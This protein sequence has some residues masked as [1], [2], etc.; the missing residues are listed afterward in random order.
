MFA[1]Y[2]MVPVEKIRGATILPAFCISL[3]AK[4]SVV[5][6][7]GR[8]SGTQDKPARFFQFCQE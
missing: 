5:S 1:P 4:I 2:R 3:A 6:L 7:L 8:E